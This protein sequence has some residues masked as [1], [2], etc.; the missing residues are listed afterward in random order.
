MN[1][2]NC[3]GTMVVE[4]ISP[5]FP[6]SLVG[7]LVTW[8]SAPY[9]L[10]MCLQWYSYMR[11]GVKNHLTKVRTFQPY[12]WHNVIARKRKENIFEHVIKEKKMKQPVLM[13]NKRK[14]RKVYIILVNIA[15][16][17]F[18]DKY[19]LRHRIFC[20]LWLVRFT[21]FDGNTWI[22]RLYFDENFEILQLFR[23]KL[24]LKHSY[25]HMIQLQ[26]CQFHFLHEEAAGAPTW[27]ATHVGGG[28]VF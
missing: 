24:F 11:I 10:S 6:L 8:P 14:H 5:L 12:P 26:A 17:D 21:P 9:P 7:E 18:Y 19:V 2:M 15:R 3:H 20:K 22:S 23:E 25:C 27:W 4:W 16:S 1:L 28:G 13:A